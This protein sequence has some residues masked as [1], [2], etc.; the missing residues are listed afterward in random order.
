[1]IEIIGHALNQW[2]VGRSAKVTN[3]EADHFHFANKGD[4]KAV[5]MEIVDS[6][7][8]IP[9]YL[10]QTGK[11]LCVYAVK[12]GVTIESRTFSVRNR[13]RPES[14]V[15]EEDQR[16]YIYEL[17]TSAEVA[18]DA[19]NQAAGVANT[20]S[21][22]ASLAAKEANNS[23][24]SANIAAKNANDAADEANRVAQD[25]Q[26]ARDSGEFTGPGIVIR[27]SYGTEAEL[28]A[29]NPTCEPGEYYL[30]GYD[31]YT[32]SK[33]ENK[34]L[35]VG[36]IQGTGY[37]P[38]ITIASEE[39]LSAALLNIYQSMSDGYA[40]TF[41]MSITVANLSIGGGIWFVTVFRST[42]K[43]GFAEA[44]RYGGSGGLFYTNNLQEG[45]WSGWTNIS[46]SKFAPSGYGLNNDF[47]TTANA[48]DVNGYLTNGWYKYANASGVTLVPGFVV[49]YAVIR[50]DS[51][52]T[53]YVEQTVYPVAY[54]GCVIQ[55]TY[56]NDAWGE[57]EWVNPPMTTGVEYRTTERY[58]GSAV[59]KK[60][61]T[62]G[63]V[64]W[65]RDGE[66]QWHLLSSADYIATATVE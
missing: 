16:N 66:S 22:S 42:T 65:R 37:A 49:Y 50:V 25:L 1:M 64:L 48:A 54:P 38:V 24:D 43:Y 10:L 29:A 47:K 32:W 31:L 11:Q 34:W 15:Y 60:I 12:D 27:G 53:G 44:V 4:L 9:D 14:Y 52:S 35:N 8:K 59:Y 51:Y 26:D 45:T 61:D 56:R 39:A 30:V 17:I 21:A 3:I 23:A 40:K 36:S 28:I 7:A 2:D 58:N 46:P 33:R 20:A 63:N 62:N 5:V 55:R 57:F 19:A 18:V 6:L 41:R 13:E